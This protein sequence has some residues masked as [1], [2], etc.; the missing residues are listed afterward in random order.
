MSE[1][2]EL[3][4]LGSLWS[5]MAIAPRAGMQQPQLVLSQGT[6]FDVNVDSGRGDLGS[7]ALRRPLCARER[8]ESPTSR[9]VR[10][11]P[12]ATKFSQRGGRSSVRLCAQGE[13]SPPDLPTAGAGSAIGSCS[14][15]R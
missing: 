11:A 3:T 10:V 12:T 9:G 2:I 1:K 4:A 6:R 8:R 15:Q 13:Y 5:A 7:R 14:H